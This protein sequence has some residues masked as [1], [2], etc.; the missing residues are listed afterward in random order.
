MT[1]AP[2]PQLTTRILTAWANLKAARLDGSAERITAA[3]TIFNEL[4][5]Q[6]PTSQHQHHEHA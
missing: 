2:E 1:T 5:D 6:L 3:A 4:M